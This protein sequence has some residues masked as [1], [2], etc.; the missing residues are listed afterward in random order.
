[1]PSTSFAP[2]YT[3]AGIDL[4]FD[5]ARLDDLLDAAGIDIVV[6]TSKHNIQYLLGGYRF[7]FFN[8]F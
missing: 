7:F 6:V 5:S 8:H 1:M 3:A 2:P 4:P